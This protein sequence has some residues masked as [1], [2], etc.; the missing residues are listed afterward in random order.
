VVE[1]RV[2]NVKEIHHGDKKIRNLGGDNLLMHPGPVLEHP[3]VC[4]SHFSQERWEAYKE[5][6]RFFR[7]AS[8][9]TYWQ[10]MQ[11][12]HGYNPPP[13]WTLAGTFF[14]NMYPAGRVFEL[15]VLGKVIWLQA[16]AMLDVAYLL[17]MFA[18]LYWAFG[19]RTFAVGAIVWG[20]QASAPFYW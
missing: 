13:V 15:P 9:K 18:A 12:D 14:A 10:D 11:T 16:L 20:C 19:W 4:K 3:E 6:V 7:M 17:G 2:D 1:R 5:D 8:D